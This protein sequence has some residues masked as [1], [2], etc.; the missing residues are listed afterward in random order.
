MAAV[1]VRRI[2][3]GEGT[4][5]KE[6]RLAALRDA[7]HAF[8]SDVEEESAWPPDAWADRAGQRSEGYDAANFVAESEEGA[9]G[10]VGAY[11]SQEEPGTVELVSMWVA[12]AARGQGIG[13]QLVERVVDWAREGAA[14]RVALW[15]M[16]G[17]E[18]ALAL[19]ERT[20]FV[21][22]AHGMPADHPCSEETRMV[23]E[24]PP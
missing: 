17:N 2:G 7:P 14:R 9:V 16:R 10:L 3:A 1:E 21:R 8:A 13:A 11:R 5:L 20:G 18:P 6:V 4:L 24:L 22:T 23:R 19:Y 15:V 12:P